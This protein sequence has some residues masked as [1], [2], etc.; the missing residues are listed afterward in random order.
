MASH[1]G[2]GA[3]RYNLALQHLDGIDVY[4]SC[5][6]AVKLLK[7]ASERGPWARLLL[8]AHNYLLKDELKASF[9]HYLESSYLGT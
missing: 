8:K 3:S 4:Y 6:L 7:D 9:I 2:H 1:Q 5:D